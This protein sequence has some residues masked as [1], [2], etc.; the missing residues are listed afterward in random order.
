MMEVCVRAY[1]NEDFE[2]LAQSFLDLQEQTV[3]IDHCTYYRARKDFD[4]KRYAESF[5]CEIAAADHTIFVAEVDRQLVGHMVVTV[6]TMG[7][8]QQR[9]Y[10]CK[11]LGSIME[12]FVQAAY[13]SLGIGAAL[14]EKAEE[15]CKDNGCDW[16]SVE[17]IRGNESA[18]EFYKR[19]AYMEHAA[20]LLK[21]LKKL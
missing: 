12:L 6:E 15:Y 1:K 18:L 9:E 14:M 5:L 3:S 17:V 10:Y 2:Q 21:K 7:E 16:I 20:T 19:Q 11:K 8:K 4:H 13:R